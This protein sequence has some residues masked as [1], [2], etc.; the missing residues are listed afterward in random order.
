MG[1]SRGLPL[2]DPPQMWP[3]YPTPHRTEGSKRT[4]CRLYMQPTLAPTE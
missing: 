3:A 4:K 1:L 2:G